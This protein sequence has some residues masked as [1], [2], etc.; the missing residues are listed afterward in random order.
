[1]VLH[2]SSASASRSRRWTGAESSCFPG[3]RTVRRGHGLCPEDWD[4]VDR[5][6]LQPTPRP[7]MLRRPRRPP[8]GTPSDRRGPPPPEPE[9]RARR[10]RGFPRRRW[11]RAGDRDGGRRRPPRCRP[12]R[13]QGGAKAFEYQTAAG[14]NG[15]DE[16]LNAPRHRLPR[17][18]VSGAFDQPAFRRR[19]PPP[20]P[21]AR[22]RTVCAPVA[23]HDQPVE[24]PARFRRL[25]QPVLKRRQEILVDRIAHAVEPLL[26]VHVGLEPAALVG[27]V[28][29]L[30][31]RCSPVPSRNIELET[32]RRGAGPPGLAA[33][34]RPCRSDSRA[35]TVGRPCPSR[36][37]IRSRK[38]RKNT[39]SQRSSSAGA[40]PSRAARPRRRAWR[41][42]PRPPDPTGGSSG[43]RSRPA[44]RR[45]ASATP[46]NLPVGEGI[47]L[48]ARKTQPS[49]PAAVAAART[50]AIASWTSAGQR[51]PARVP[52]QHGEFRVVQRGPLG[53]AEDVGEL[54]DP[55]HPGGPAASSSR[56]PARCAASARAVSPGP[57]PASSVAKAT[58]CGSSPGE[59]WSAGRIHLDEAAG[60]EFRRA[61]RRRSAPAPPGTAGGGAKRSGRHQGAAGTGEA[62]AGEAGSVIGS[63]VRGAHGAPGKQPTQV[64]I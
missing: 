42:C 25:G 20:A 63:S 3:P 2:W 34:G 10:H 47:G 53:V 5:S 11:R 57:G 15:K 19:R 16:P 61:G 60:G 28:G 30:A 43:P 48:G 51:V 59:T 29:Q 13:P 12:A 4:D 6:A 26:E 40:S 8:V 7:P 55:R 9:S 18:S 32:A 21:T 44:W 14:R 45:K 33:P 56:I 49:R 36:G 23:Q 17:R 46:S 54:K 1:M 39:S 22:P 64:L 38:T 27:G 35:A 31:E 58:R 24:A 50:S 62:G 52:F 37:S 41:G